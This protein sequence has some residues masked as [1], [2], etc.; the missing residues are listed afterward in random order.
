MLLS[1]LLA[2]QSS[3]TV[4]SVPPEEP[5]PPEPEPVPIDL[6]LTVDEPLALS[7]V[8]DE[9]VVAGRVNDPEAIVWVEGYR[10]KVGSAGA[11]RVTVPVANF[12]SDLQ[13]TID[14]EASN[15]SKH[16]R[17][18]LPV[19]AGSDPLEAWPG[20]I[21]LRFTPT[22]VDHL[23]EI[24]ERAVVDLDL[25]GQLEALLPDLVVGSFSATPLGITHWP[26]QAEMTSGP[27]GLDLQVTIRKLKLAYAVQ[28]GTFLGDG[29][30]ELGFDTLTLGAAIEPS[31]DASG[32]FALE[33]TDTTFV[34]DQPE[35]TIG[36]AGSPALESLLNGALGGV[37][38][39]IE[40][41]VDGLVSTFGRIELFGPIGTEL[42]LLGTPVGIS[43]DRLATDDDG[44]GAVI[45][46]DLGTGSPGVLRVPSAQE[47]GF[48]SDLAIAVHEGLFQP[49]LQSDI[50]DLL[51]QDLEL[52]GLLGGILG[53]PIEALPG[54]DGVPDDVEGWC[55][56]LSIGDGRTVRL[57]EGT[58]P[59][60]TIVLPEVFVD[61]GVTTP[62]EDCQDWLDMTLALEADLNVTSGTKVGIGLRVVDGHVT[63]YAT[64]DD[65]DE[66]GVVQG[67][68]G[69]LSALTGLLGG[70]LQFDLADFFGGLDT[71][72]LPLGDL[73]LQITGNVPATNA[74]GEPIEG[75][76]MI[77]LSLWD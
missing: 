44:I 55:L 24:V 19:L 36:G 9:V 2:C 43:I 50:L 32:I 31:I 47:A 6:V 67:L 61:I 29:D 8:G 11:F 69:L 57:R 71:S 56:N 48:R 16:L 73:S 12:A 21:T 22:G 41:L 40:G 33:V 23:A 52:G 15:P 74:D 45:G 27:D 65:W 17:E 20:A 66:Q 53:G 14:V 70:A 42:D 13:R 3:G 62:Q 68:G 25:V 35:I 10:A 46:V 4:L 77:T 63:H 58:A 37:T 7:Y 38:G 75:L 51:E 64:D 76:R 59:M 1:L 72:T 60:A 28:T 54:G 49:L 26:V 30:V 39:T 34:L 18:R 5:G